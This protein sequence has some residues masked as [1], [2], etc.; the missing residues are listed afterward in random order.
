MS[1]LSAFCDKGQPRY[2]LTIPGFP[3]ISSR[4]SASMSQ[5]IE[6]RE[7]RETLRGARNDVDPDAILS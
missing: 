3:R 4:C 5:L 7:N 2:S 1:V 6:E